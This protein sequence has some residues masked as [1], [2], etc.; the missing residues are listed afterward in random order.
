MGDKDYDYYKIKDGDI[1]KYKLEKY[2]KEFLLN[3]VYIVNEIMC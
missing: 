2:I 3:M 1:L